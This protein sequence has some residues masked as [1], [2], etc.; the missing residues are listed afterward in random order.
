MSSVGRGG[1]DVLNAGHLPALSG[2]HA[3]TSGAETR[4]A[5]EVA[6]LAGAA[7]SSIVMLMCKRRQQM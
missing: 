7:R 4:P 3:G 6:V 2:E 1:C 5:V